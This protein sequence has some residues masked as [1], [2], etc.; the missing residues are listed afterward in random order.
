[1]GAA[2]IKAGG[3]EILAGLP[4]RIHH[5][6]RQHAKERPTHPALAHSTTTWSYSELLAIIDSLAATLL[7]L[8]IRPG[9]RL[10]IVSENSLPLAVLV[11][12]ASAIDAWAVVASPRVSAREIDQIL[13]HSGV[14]RTFYVT[15]VPGAAKDHAA[16]H[17]A[18]IE[19]V[20]RLGELAIGPLNGTVT[21]EA[22]END[23][24]GQVAVPMYTSG[25]TDN[26]KAVMLTHR[27][28]LYNAR[29]SGLLR[30]LSPPDRIYGVLPMSHIV[31]LSIILI[32]SLMFGATIQVAPRYEPAELVRAIAED[33]ITVLFGCSTGKILKH[34][35][36]E[37]ARQTVST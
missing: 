14:R 23:S 24:A 9:E 29:V 21:A 35:L 8:G 13:H 7:G 11:L 34:K 3:V 28:L 17:G 5:V 36:M 10:L 25:T 1:M 15:S 37:A 18:I 22:V 4:E 26:P 19:P 12:A 20:G 27:N 33:G 2:A 16:R 32:S 30:H 31:G 6:I